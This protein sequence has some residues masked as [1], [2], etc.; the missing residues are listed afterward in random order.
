M[1]GSAGFEPATLLPLQE[2][3]YLTI[4]MGSM[5]VNSTMAK[6]PVFPLDNTPP[7]L[8]KFASSWAH[9]Y[10]RRSKFDYKNER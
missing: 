6:P 7:D 8:D 9:T 1:G 2:Y 5:N 10:I 4:L 3:Y